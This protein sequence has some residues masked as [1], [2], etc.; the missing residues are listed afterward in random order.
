MKDCRKCKHFVEGKKEYQCKR[1]KTVCAPCNR[2]NMGTKLRGC[3]YAEK[4][5]VGK[6]EKEEKGHE[7]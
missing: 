1:L 7:L 4:A 5:S 2:P 3:A 6:K